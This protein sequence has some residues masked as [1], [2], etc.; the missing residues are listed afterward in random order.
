[1]TT[2]EITGR[3]I[4]EARKRAGLTQAQLA[5]K[6]GVSKS[7]VCMWERATH[8]PSYSALIAIAKAVGV[9]P[10]A[11]MPTGQEIKVQRA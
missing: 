8:C 4:R 9:R 11:L 2:S 10:A 5:A 6:V 1:M 7:S 3:L